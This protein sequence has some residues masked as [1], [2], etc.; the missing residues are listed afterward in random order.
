MGKLDN[1]VA[2]VTGAAR[3]IGREIA[4]TLAREGADIVANALH[5]PNLES[6][7]AEIEGLGRRAK[8]VTADISRKADV[9]RM[10]DAAIG[11]F[12]KIDILVCNAGITRFAPF[13]EMTEEDWDAVIAV[14]LKGT[15]LCGQAVA[16]HMVPRKYGKII[17]VSSLSGLGARNPTMA[18]YA[19]SKAGVNNLSRVMALALGE[20]GIN[21]NVVAPGVIQTEMGLARRTPQEYAAYLD[22]YRQQTALHRVGEARDIANAVLFLA[23][24]DSSFITGQVIVSDGGVKDGLLR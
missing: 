1:K 18:N 12:D 23:S 22:L 20:H 11:A 2:L 10:V 7:V 8:A 16:K 19:A 3:G 4:L 6:L 14:D 17:N 5:M 15:F 13:L 9:D 24:D 21:V